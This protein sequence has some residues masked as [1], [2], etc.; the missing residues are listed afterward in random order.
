MNY[1]VLFCHIVNS[2]L[3]F[4]CD[5]LFL[6]FFIFDKFFTYCL[7]IIFTQDQPVNHLRLR[8]PAD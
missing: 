7:F 1:S 8:L 3:G 2:I 5:C 6:T 4:Y